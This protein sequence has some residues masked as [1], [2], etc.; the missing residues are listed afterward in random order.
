[1]NKL[2]V[3]LTEEEFAPYL[4]RVRHFRPGEYIVR[5]GE[6]VSGFGIV[7]EGVVQVFKEDYFGNRSLLSRCR[8]GDLFLEAVRLTRPEN[9][10]VNVQA[11]TAC[12]VA[13]LDYAK[14]FAPAGNCRVHARVLENLLR[15]ISTKVLALNR[16]ISILSK[17]TIR[18]KVL[19]FLKEEGG[20]STEVRIPFGRSALADYLCV[21]RSALSRELSR[22]KER[23]EID[24]DGNDFRIKIG[25]A[26]LD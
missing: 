3:G 26:P 23:G 12:S 21:D 1:M 13:V 11:V 17:R 14:L 18:D 20:G 4:E 2:S 25:L 9:S 5:A 16:K 24:F 15:V 10:P 8:E 22:M 6:P 7:L 19:C